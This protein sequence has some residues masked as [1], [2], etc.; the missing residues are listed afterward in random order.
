MQHRLQI[1]YSGRLDSLLELDFPKDLLVRTLYF[2]NQR[3]SYESQLQLLE[4]IIKPRKIGEKMEKPVW[5]SFDSVK[6]VLKLIN[7]IQ[8]CTSKELK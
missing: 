5:P 8:D 1:I 6:P 4:K 2:K 7:S 3:L